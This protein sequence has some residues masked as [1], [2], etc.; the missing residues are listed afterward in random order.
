MMMGAF[1][2]CNAAEIRRIRRML[3]EQRR[4]VVDLTRDGHLGAARGAK[5]HAAALRDRIRRIRSAMGSCG[6]RRYPLSCCSRWGRIDL[7]PERSA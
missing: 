6:R 5:E 1:A 2:P 3:R 4:W 7:Y